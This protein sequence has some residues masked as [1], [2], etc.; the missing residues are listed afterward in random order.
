MNTLLTHE[1][2]KRGVVAVLGI[3]LALTLLVP[4]P[5]ARAQTSAELQSQINQLLA[6]IAQ[7]QAQLGGTVSGGTCPAGGWTRDLGQGS[8]G[9]DVLAL[10]RFLNG[11]PDTRLA[12][13]GAG[14]PGMETQFYGPVT[15]AAVSKFQVKYRAEVLTP[16]GLVNPTGYFGAASRAKANSLCVTTVPPTTPGDD[17]DDDDNDP[18]G[19]GEASL[20]N[21]DVKSEETNLSEGDDDQEVMTV[22]FDVEDGDAEVNR[23]DL[24]FDHVSGGDDDPWD[25][26]E[27]ISI[28]VDGDEVAS[29]DI[30]DEDDWDEDEPESGDYRIRITD[31]DDFIVREGDTAEFTVA[32]SVAGSVDDADTGVEWEIFVPDD[33]I[34]ATDSV[35]ISHYIGDTDDVV[36]F[37]IDEEGGDDELMVRSSDED[38]DATTLQLDEDDRS[39]WLTVFAFDLDTEDAESDIEIGS[40]PVEV[41]FSAGTYNEFVNDARLVIDGEEFD[42]F[43][44]TNGGTDTATLTFE[45]DND[46]FVI[47]ASDRV[48]AELEIEFKALEDADEGTTLVSSVSGDDIE[49][50]G[51][52]DLEADQLGGSAT[53]ETHTLRTTGV[54]LSEVETSESVRDNDTAA[55][56]GIYTIQFEVTA[57]E[58]DIYVNRSAASGTSMGTAGVNFLVEDSDGDQVAAGSESAA[59]SS[60]ADTVGTRYRVSEGETETFTLTVSYTPDADD[61]YRVQL[62]SVNFNTEN[63]NPDTQQRALPEQDYETEYENLDA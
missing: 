40:I 44:V 43:T 60:T 39:D 58:E 15:A 26:F 5:Y 59:L 3:A 32:L 7:L 55:D 57:F 12:A 14:S 17:D 1:V 28:M 25:V 27:N 6:T 41:E 11:S 16:L 54:T 19:G 36:S 4:A 31:I 29:M 8:S 62:Y 49:A 48:T 18:L 52:D 2:L 46:D 23:I 10:Q 20:E 34:R 9:A 35:N 21:F 61:F 30:S 24:A 51:A 56:T 37:D 38:P 13:A 33:G 53:S 42:D 47:D 45:F 22:E 63:A 50:E